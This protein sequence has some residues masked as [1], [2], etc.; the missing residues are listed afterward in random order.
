MTIETIFGFLLHLYWIRDF[1]TR[2]F[3]MWLACIPVVVFFAPLGPWVMSRVS[4]GAYKNFLY[5]VFFIQYIGAVWAIKPDLRLSVL[6]VTI[7]VF[8]I[9]FF[10]LLS[11]R[12]PEKSM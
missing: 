10:R 12:N 8:G 11:L 3:D 6:S 4:Y 7:I 2:S 9:V 1:S 5:L